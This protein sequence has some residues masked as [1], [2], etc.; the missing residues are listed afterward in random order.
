MSVSYRAQL[1]GTS[2]TDGDIL[3]SLLDDWVSTGPTIPVRGVR[4]KVDATC[5]VTISDFNDNTCFDETDDTQTDNTGTIIGG[6]VAA[7]L[8]V[9][10][11]VVL[12]TI[13]IVLIILRRRKRHGQFSV[14]KAE[15]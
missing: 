1:S 13:V 8:I 7:V 15:E 14:E 9:I 11:A 2:E 12:T 10:I 6:A 3:I 4:M 5:A